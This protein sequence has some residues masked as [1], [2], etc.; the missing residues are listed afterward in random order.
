MGGPIMGK[1]QPLKRLQNLLES[2]GSLKDKTDI[3]LLHDI[4]SN[5]IN[6]HVSNNFRPCSTRKL[7][8]LA[9]VQTSNSFKHQI[10]ATVYTR[11]SQAPSVLTAI[12]KAGIMVVQA[13]NLISKQKRKQPQISEELKQ[14]HPYLTFRVIQY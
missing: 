13:Q 2:G 1:T 6:G 3:V 11:R 14:V 8:D 7:V 5:S 9:Y 12:Q 10:H 4:V